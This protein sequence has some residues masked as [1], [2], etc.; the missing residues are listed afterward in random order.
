MTGFRQMLKERQ[1]KIN[2]LLCVGLD[3]LP[4]KVPDCIKAPT[5]ARRVFIHMRECVD[6]TASRAS[7]FKPQKAYYEAIEGGQHVLQALVDHIHYKYPDIPVFLDCKRGDI[8]RT[9]TQYREAHFTIDGVDGMN[10][11]PYMG[12]DCMKSLFDP[13]HPERSIVSLCYTSNKG[14]RQIQDM[15]LEDGRFF[16]EFVAAKVLEWAEKIG[17]VENTGLVMAAAHELP[18]KGSG[19]VFDEHLTRVRNIVGNKLWFL[20]PALGTQ[21]GFAEA[22]IQKGFYGY[23]SIVGSSS[24]G[25]TF[26]SAETDFAEAS[27][28]EAEKLVVQMRAAMPIGPF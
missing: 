26:A 24:S 9:Q 11:S 5:A 13:V 12:D 21:G 4:D 22:T 6:A 20:V 18:P 23:G 25:I 10:F 15:K 1:E 7:C 27:A 3:P 8:D 16:Y 14:A 19:I 17:C 2:S 28:K